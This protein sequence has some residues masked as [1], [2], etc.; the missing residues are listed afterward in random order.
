MALRLERGSALKVITVLSIAPLL[1]LS[2]ANAH[3]QDPV[4]V[5]EADMSVAFGVTQGHLV[6][7]PGQLVFINEERRDESFA[8]RHENIAE[9]SADE[10]ILSVRTTRPVGGMQE[11]AFRV[12][13]D[14]AARMV[15][16]SRGSG[17]FLVSEATREDAPGEA[18]DQTD[19][20]SEFRVS[21]NHFLGDCEGILQV[22]NRG[23]AYQSVTESEH[24]VRWNNAQIREI[25]RSNR[26]SLRI[27]PVSGDQYDF[28]FV[29]ERLMSEDVF[30]SLSDRVARAQLV[31][32]EPGP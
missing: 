5:V 24:S 10:E 25:D 29:G 26:D 15:S 19:A 27:A 16:W 1:A 30:R 2:I 18:P 32:G 6:T 8:I 7:V 23:V 12:D 9:A 17:A 11:F 31:T 22:T 3:A 21:H 20:S 4:D 14:A 13:S 28:E